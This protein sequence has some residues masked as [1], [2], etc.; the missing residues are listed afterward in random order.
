M[1]LYTCGDSHARWTFLGC[2]DVTSNWLGPLTMHRFGRDVPMLTRDHGVPQG[3]D[4][5]MCLG[6]IDV[7]C[8]VARFALE[9]PG[10]APGVLSDLCGRFEAAVLAN[11]AAGGWRKTAIMSVVPPAKKAYAETNVDYP[12]EG[13]DA[14]RAANTAIL[15][16]MLRAA[17]YRNGWVYLDVHR[18][19]SD[20][21]GTLPPD[22]S[23]G[24]VHVGNPSLA[25][26]E[27]R[28]VGL[29]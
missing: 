5:L 13:T 9:H 16:G 6:E 19:Y 27:L 11:A 14:E 10:G 29:L 28:R 3:S 15:N 2:E 24:N 25:L 26:A 17:C 7:R 8:H 1:P 21:D 23:D 20:E 12:F 22:A 4:V 18:L